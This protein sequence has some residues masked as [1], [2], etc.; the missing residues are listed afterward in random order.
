M[1]LATGHFRNYHIRDSSQ[2]CVHW[3]RHES[4]TEGNFAAWEK[5]FRSPRSKQRNIFLHNCGSGQ[6]SDLPP[7]QPRMLICHW[8]GSVQDALGGSLDVSSGATVL[9]AGPWGA[10]MGVLSAG[11]V[12]S[13]ETHESA[14][15]I[16]AHE[17]TEI[18]SLELAEHVLL[19]CQFAEME[20]FS[21]TISIS[22]F[23]S[24][25]QVEFI[26]RHASQGGFYILASQFWQTPEAWLVHGKLKIWASHN[27]PG[28]SSL[29]SGQ[30]LKIPLG[31][32]LRVWRAKMGLTR[33]H[34]RQCWGWLLPKDPP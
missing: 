3:F 6:W 30:S 4:S 9:W 8:E 34:I 24:W 17:S 15:T 5:L 26:L 23:S 1:S 28:C 11:Q 22:W 12:S 16:F 33:E 27:G 25:S 14:E 19:E 29:L 21:G 32:S 18:C 2:E 10:R 31:Q 20:M 7:E 13:W